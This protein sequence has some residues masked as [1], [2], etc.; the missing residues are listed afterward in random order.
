MWVKDFQG[1]ASSDH[2]MVQMW[3]QKWT[4]E[5]Y[6]K[7]DLVLIRVLQK[8]TTNGTCMYEER[9]LFYEI[10]SGHSGGWQV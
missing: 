5:K 6:S 10:G 1:G 4:S 9:D 3:S 8:N 7:K 2:D